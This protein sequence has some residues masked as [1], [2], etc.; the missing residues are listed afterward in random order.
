M[1][2]RNI[3]KSSED[4]DSI[5]NYFRNKRFHFFFNKIESLS[6]PVS[7]LDLGGKI[8]FWENRGLSGNK[9]FQITIINLTLETSP[10]SN[11]E[12]KIGNVLELKNF[13]NNSFDIVFSNSVIEH[14]YTFENQKKMAKEV[15]RIGK[16]HIIQTPNKYFF[17]EPHYIIP[18][19]QFIPKKIQLKILTKTKISRLKKWDEKF[20]KQYVNEIRLMKQ[21]ELNEIFPNSNIYYEK[22]LGMTKSFTIHTF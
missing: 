15:L 12:T 18:F 2:I 4:K 1:K 16:K 13:K 22:F 3:F 7:I 20:A 17:I 19:F 6:K 21:K 10:Y 8:N 5:G 11:I 9:N 14:L